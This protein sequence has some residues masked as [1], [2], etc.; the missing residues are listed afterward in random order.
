[1]K[2]KRPKPVVLIVL[3]GWGIAPP[4]P[5][6]AISLAKTPNMDKYW[7]GYPH[8][9]LKACGRAVGLPEGEMGTSEAGHLTLGAGRIFFQDFSRISLSIADG[10]FYKN[11]AFLSSCEFV[12]SNRSQLHL[13]G[14]LSYGS[15]H[16][17]RD[18]L[19]ALLR[20]IKS[21]GLKTNQVKLHLFTDGR[22][23]PQKSALSLIK[24]LE[25]VIQKIRIG[26]I[27]SL[28]GRYYAMDRDRRWKRTQKAYE[29]LVLGKGQKAKSPEAIIEKY[30][31]NGVTD[32][33]F[34]PTLF[35]ASKIKDGDAVIFYN[36]RTD[37]AR[38]LT[39]AFVASKFHVFDR[40]QVLKR[41]FFTTMTEF[42]K[43]LH[44]SAVAFPARTVRPSLPKVISE[45]GLKQLHVAESEKYAFVTY[46]FNG[47]LEKPEK[48]EDRILIPSPEIPTYDL[49][50]EMS[51][52]EISK[53]IIKKIKLR[54]YDFILVN[55]ASPD[56][57][58]HTGVLQAGIKACE[59]VDKCV[60]KIVDLVLFHHGVC[61]IVGDHGNVEEMIDPRT[62]EVSTQHSLNEVP[63]ILI[64]NE[65]LGKTKI[66]PSGTLADV[67]PTILKIM[68]IPKPNLM[69]GKSFVL[70]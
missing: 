20:L 48:G 63:F 43:G 14:L 7:A 38:Q 57:V 33:F 40:K 68:N 60:G 36:F 9:K 58:G 1:M 24:E 3:D 4:L 19:Y 8:T 41:I 61:I 62:G 2:L 70:K 49:K 42:E 50:P 45:Q 29:A 46:Y 67:A 51:S 11:K 18:H 37:R 13:L 59:A 47:L 28:S 55:F 39:R 25:S 54:H 10:S 69:S 44:V 32:E 52:F 21:Q 66:L 31:Q 5:G 27:V 16:A 15:V 53:E 17:D 12:K 23:S 56:M 22:D 64:D 26:K 34:L 6:N 30:Y 35:E 65:W